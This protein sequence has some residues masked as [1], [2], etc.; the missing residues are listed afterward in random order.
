MSHGV[1]ALAEVEEEATLLCTTN[2]IF[3]LEVGPQFFILPD[4]FLEPGGGPIYLNVTSA[5][6]KKD[7]AREPRKEWGNPVRHQP[8]WSSTRGCFNQHQPH[9]QA[10]R[11]LESTTP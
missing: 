10:V 2:V 8:R 9:Q 6:V 7:L 1:D 11:S 5:Q 3:L 4:D